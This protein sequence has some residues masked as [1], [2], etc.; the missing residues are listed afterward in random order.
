MNGHFHLDGFLPYRLHRAAEAIGRGF[1]EEYKAI[2]GLTRPEWRALAALGQRGRLTATEIGQH[3]DMHKTQVSRAV[4]RLAARGW[5]TRHENP[6][7]RRVEFLELTAAGQSAFG[8]LTQIALRY[9]ARL[10]DRLGAT[11]A[12]ALDQYLAVIE[13]PPAP[14]PAP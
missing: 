1:A 14:S 11:G 12:K 2:Y 10:V 9:Q 6:R 8:R 13:T 5:L 7:D 4:T 3:A